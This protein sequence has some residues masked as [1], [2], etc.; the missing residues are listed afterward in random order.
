MYTSDLNLVVINRTVSRSPHAYRE[1]LKNHICGFG[2]EKSKTGVCGS[3]HL[4]KYRERIVINNKRSYRCKLCGYVPKMSISSHINAHIHNQ[5]ICP[6]RI[7]AKANKNQ[8]ITGY[9]YGGH[10][11]KVAPNH[12]NQCKVDSNSKIK[13]QVKDKTNGTLIKDSKC[14]PFS[15]N[16]LQ[17]NDKLKKLIVEGSVGGE[18]NYFC[19]RNN[20]KYYNNSYEK[21]VRHVK[22][23]LISSERHQQKCSNVLV[24]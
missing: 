5:Y 24:V 15:N 8:S 3:D 12:I 23:K 2:I 22:D 1:H 20:Y 21:V 16:K 18:T 10:S 17:I 9:E 7:R 11:K 13:V 19:K 14:S 6:Q 4:K